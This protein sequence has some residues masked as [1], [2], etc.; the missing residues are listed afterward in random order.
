MIYGYNVMNNIEKAV[1]ALR[2]GECI[3]IHDWNN[4]ENEIDMVCY[5]GFVSVSIIYKLRTEAGGLI[6]YGTS[7]NIMKILGLTFLSE[8]FNQHEILKPLVSK[9][10]RYGDVSPFVLWVN[11]IDVNT[12]ISDIDK[13][14]TVSKLDEVV[15][16]I[17]SGRIEDGKHLFYENF[18][19]PGHVPIVAARDIRFRRGH[20]ELAIAL[21]QLAKLRPSVVFAEMLGYGTSLNLNEAK[22]YADENNLVLVT[23]D[24]IIKALGI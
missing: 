13:V 24:E 1:K 15:M 22:R 14:K 18:Y 10:P 12:G 21:T 16:L 6:C 3:L 2:S 4:R 8:L 20:T 17:H 7:E 5:A 9:K 11:S 23:G 19:S